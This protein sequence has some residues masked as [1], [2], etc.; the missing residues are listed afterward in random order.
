MDRWTLERGANISAAIA[1]W[2]AV[3][4]KNVIR[5]FFSRSATE[6]LTRMGAPQLT[7]E[8]VSAVIQT[9]QKIEN[10]SDAVTSGLGHCRL[11]RHISFRPAGPALDR[12]AYQV[13]F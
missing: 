9:S 3:E 5:H 8:A 13:S 11:S 2:S 6:R 7:A 4:L 12:K 1:I 10:D